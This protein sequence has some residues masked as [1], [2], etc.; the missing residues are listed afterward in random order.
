MEMS[1]ANIQKIQ[2]NDTVRI[3]GEPERSVN[4]RARVLRVE[5]N[6]VRVTNINMPFSGTMTYHFFE[7]HEVEKVVRNY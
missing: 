6:G 3:L 7:F 1:V 4:A 2:V 5:D